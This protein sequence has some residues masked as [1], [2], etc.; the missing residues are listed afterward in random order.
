M[1]AHLRMQ[2][3]REPLQ[4]FSPTQHRFQTQMATESPIIEMG[5]IT[6]E[7][8]LRGTTTWYSDCLLVFS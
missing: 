5:E 7:E 1:K 6:P 3:S 2:G 8:S 4:R